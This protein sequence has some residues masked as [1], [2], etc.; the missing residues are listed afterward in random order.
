MSKQITFFERAL[1]Y[2]FFLK[3]I[4]SKEYHLRILVVNIKNRQNYDFLSEKV[5][6]LR[7]D[8]YMIFFN[9]CDF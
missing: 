3:S 1:C 2:F 6:V 4:T 7:I 5:S 8:L 9:I